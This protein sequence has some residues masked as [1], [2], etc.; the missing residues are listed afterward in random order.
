MISVTAMAL[1]LGSLV[2]ADAA[3]LGPS[4]C[5]GR[6]E[7]GIEALSPQQIEGYLEGRSMRMALPAQV[8]S[9]QQMRG[10]AF[11]TR[12]DEHRHGHG[13]AWRA[14]TTP[15]LCS[16]LDVPGIGRN[17]IASSAGSAGSVA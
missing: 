9:Y 3:R 2:V 16:Q 15:G 7:R 8:Q 12:S 14:V 6:A 11:A 5:A 17:I 10:Q 1:G 4:P 13:R